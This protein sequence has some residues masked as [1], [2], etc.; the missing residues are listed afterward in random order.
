[1]KEYVRKAVKAQLAHLASKH[2]VDNLYLQISA[3]LDVR[4]LVGTNVFIGP[5]RG[6][7]ISPDALAIV[8]RDIVARQDPRVV[9]FGSGESTLSI[10]A[11]LRKIGSGSLLSF[12]HDPAH[13]HNMTGR[14]R[15]AGLL[16]FA[17]VRTLPLRDYQV[18]GDRG[19]FTSY[20]MDGQDYDF[21]V[22]LID[23]PVCSV[24]GDKTR[25]IPL[26]WCAARLRMNCSIYLDDADRP[27][28][29]DLLQSLR[30]AYPMLIVETLV[31]EKGLAKIT[32]LQ[33]VR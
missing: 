29:K 5:L 15:D 31:A 11:V 17:T 6:W 9:E 22:A 28:E 10:A 16:P 13:T 14:L 26:D 24:H 2:D 4:E 3:L 21:D 18:D 27:P 7:A 30:K 20:N 23:G 1:M 8:L 25:S 33:G 32:V 19:Q 12:E